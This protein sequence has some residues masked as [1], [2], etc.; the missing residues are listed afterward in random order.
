M[1]KQLRRGTA[2]LLLLTVLCLLVAC[3]DQRLSDDP[4]PTETDQNA[5]VRIS[6]VGD[7]Y[8]SEDQIEDARLADGSYNFM[9]QFSDVYAALSKADLT[10]GNFEGNFAGAP[11]G[12]EHGSYPDEFAVALNDAG[13]DLLQTANSFSIYNGLAGLRRT[14]DVIENNGMLCSGTYRDASERSDGQ[15]TVFEFNGI[16]VAVLSFTKGLGGM[17]LPSGEEYCVDLLYTDYADDYEEIDEAGITAAIDKA[18]REDPD[19][20]IAMVHWGSENV[21]EVSKRQE[22]IADLMFHN[23]VDAILGSHPH[24]VAKVEQRTVRMDDGSRK[25]VLIAYSLG[26]FCK[27]SRGQTNMSPILNLVFTRDAFSGETT[28]T[29][30]SCSS[31]AVMDN[32]EEAPDRY[33]ILDADNAIALYEGNYYDRITW[34]LYQSLLS[35]REYLL[36]VIG[37]S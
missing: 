19:V 3:D 18:K 6:A 28:L 32:G 4:V 27:V 11:Y 14:K 25:N 17:S 1:T 34:D 10:I 30:V 2:V 16:R 36:S 31:V 21:L 12:Q 15:V 7:I 5:T 29:G 33:T 35:K 9:P 22:Q 8:L 24:L 13:F 37:L 20:I 26:D 23:G